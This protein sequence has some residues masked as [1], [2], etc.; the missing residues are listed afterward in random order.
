[1]RYLRLYKR[2]KKGVYL[3]SSKLQPTVFPV[4]EW[5]I[6]VL[7]D[8]ILDGACFY[9]FKVITYAVMRTGFRI[10]LESSEIRPI[11]DKELLKR[12]SRVNPKNKARHFRNHLKEHGPNTKEGRKFRKKQTDKMQNM[13]F[14]IR[15]IKQR[16]AYYFMREYAFPSPLWQNIYS[17]RPVEY[18]NK[19]L[20]AK[21][22]AFVDAWPMSLRATAGSAAI[23]FSNPSNP[24]HVDHV[25]LSKTGLVSSGSSDNPQSGIRYP[26]SKLSGLGE[27]IQGNQYFRKQIRNLTGKKTWS[28]ALKIYYQYMSDA[29]HLLKLKRLP[30]AFGNIDPKAIERRSRKEKWNYK[31]TGGKGSKAFTRER[32]KELKEF[33]KINGHCYI[34]RTSKENPRLG[35]WLNNQRMR[36]RKG[37]LPLET[38]RILEDMGVTWEIGSGKWWY[39]QSPGYKQAREEKWQKMFKELEKYI[40]KN[41]H[42]QVPARY[43]KNPGLGYWAWDQRYKIGKGRL[44]E[45][46]IFQLDKV[47]FDW[48]IELGVTSTE[49]VVRVV[50]GDTFYT[51]K[52]M[53]SIRLT[54]VDTPEKGE[55]GYKE[56]KKALQDLI[57]G[58]EVVVYTV[59]KDVY[60]RYVAHVKVDGIS[61][62]KEMKKYKKKRR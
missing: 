37:E 32:I 54:E 12:Y 62:N 51:E 49:R 6:E 35:Q 42:A 17:C 8:F 14:Y 22:A 24:N 21:I 60:R 29:E 2:G 15:A 23:S 57:N 33:K 30:T 4:E 27:A 9:G 48:E 45:E 19:P 55:E 18:S 7:R 40:K 38:Y 53:K 56:A 3:C 1:M 50:D 44:S 25:I 46:R 11:S 58:K 52:R 13:P 31:P 36:Q 59:A 26:E 16:F 34:P 39:M 61:V 10:L 20:I 28:Q 43:R 41:G 5:D 47:G